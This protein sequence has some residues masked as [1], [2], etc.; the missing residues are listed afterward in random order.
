MDSNKF[1]LTQSLYMDQWGFS[2]GKGLRNN[3]GFATQFHDKHLDEEIGENY[4][5][6]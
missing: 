4:L 6:Q 3:E 1:D 5:Y 2:V